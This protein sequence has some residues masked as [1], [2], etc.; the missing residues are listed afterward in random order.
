MYKKIDW[1]L[2]S[3]NITCTSSSSN[4]LLPDLNCENLLFSTK[5][6]SVILLCM[7]YRLKTGNRPKYLEALRHIAENIQ[8]MTYQQLTESDFAINEAV[9]VNC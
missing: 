7:F 6:F 8:Y 4:Y 1:I 9:Q 2:E 5:H 3:S